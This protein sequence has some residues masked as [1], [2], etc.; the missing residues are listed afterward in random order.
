MGRKRI[1][2]DV[3]ARRGGIQSESC[4]NDNTTPFSL[5]YPLSSCSSYLSA[6]DT[7]GPVQR[8]ALHGGHLLVR[9]SPN[10]GNRADPL[11][12]LTDRHA[13]PA[14]DALVWVKGNGVVW[15]VF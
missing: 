1:I 2:T 3:R 12:L 7:F 15:R 8:Q 11:N 5:P 9:A 14:L 10:K 6:L 13:S 4:I